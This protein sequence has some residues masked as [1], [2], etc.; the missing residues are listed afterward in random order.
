MKGIGEGIFG[1]LKDEATVGAAAPA[2]TA[3]PAAAKPAA[4][5]NAAK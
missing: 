3:K 2:K 1:K 4:V 5:K